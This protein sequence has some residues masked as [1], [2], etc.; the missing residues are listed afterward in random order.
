MHTQT[1]VWKLRDRPP[2]EWNSPDPGGLGDSLQSEDD[3]GGIDGS[4]QSEEWTSSE[5]SRT[6]RTEC[7][8]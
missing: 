8:S 7:S 3:F 2:E 4:L 5:Q 6:E 1:P